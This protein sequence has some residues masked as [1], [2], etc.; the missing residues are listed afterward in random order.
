MTIK[1]NI[2]KF[3]LQVRIYMREYTVPIRVALNNEEE[4]PRAALEPLQ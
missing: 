3:G 4:S 2:F 1:A